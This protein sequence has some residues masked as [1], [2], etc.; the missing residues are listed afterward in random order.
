MSKFYVGITDS[1]WYSCLKKEYENGKLTQPV[2][3]WRPGGSAFKVIQKGDL[4]LF[5]L[6]HNKKSKEEN[7]DIVGGGTFLRYEKMSI[8]EAWQKYGRRNG[9]DSLEAMHRS[10]SSIQKKNDVQSGAEIGCILLE[11]VFFF[12]DGIKWPQKIEWPKGIVSGKSF[13]TDE[14]TGSSLYQLIGKSFE[15]KQKSD[16]EIIDEIDEDINTLS[17]EGA[18]RVALVKTRVNQ[19][20]FR[21]R[22]LKEYDS[23]CLC[24]VKN[25]KLLIAS[26]I[27]PWAASKANEKL[28]VENGFLMCPNHDA[29]FDGGFITFK[30]SGEIVISD[31][32]SESD[33]ESINVNDGMKIALSKKNKEYLCYHR[34]KVYKGKVR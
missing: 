25:K 26:H 9:R 20:I 33:Y 7:G 13:S 12:D 32:L 8:S 4:F 21:E 5:K 17:L 27:K 6:R 19:G 11:D 30:D 16:A 29:L 14:K 1:E 31:E 34:K 22:L 2:N 10:L 28:D 24:D 18:E 15:G 3:F 23:C